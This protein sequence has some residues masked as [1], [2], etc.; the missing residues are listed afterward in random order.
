MRGVV[1]LVVAYIAIGLVAGWCARFSR[2]RSTPPARNV[3]EV[4]IAFLFWPVPLIVLFIAWVFNRAV[5]LIVPFSR[6]LEFKVT[7]LLKE[8]VHRD[9]FGVLYK[10]PSPYGEMRIV[11]VQDSTG[12]YWLP[13][14]RSMQTAKQAVAW[15]YDKTP[16]YF[17]P[18]RY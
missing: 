16:E 12:T 4:T 13:V 11:K 1:L 3:R 8:E 10:G 14:P 2:E 15:T 18:V 17:N 9:D 7:L 5:N 6:W